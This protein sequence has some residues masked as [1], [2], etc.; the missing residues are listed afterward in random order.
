ML[1]YT[2]ILKHKGE[3]FYVFTFEGWDNL[4]YEL[5]Y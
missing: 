2:F 4:V 1:Y 3:I 5:T